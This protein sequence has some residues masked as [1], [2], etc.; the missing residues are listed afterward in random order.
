MYEEIVFWRWHLHVF[1]R[2]ERNLSPKLQ[3]GSSF[4]TKSP[5][6][7]KILLL[8]SSCNDCSTSPR[9]RQKNILSACLTQ[10]ELDKTDALLHEVSTI[11]DKQLTN[12][13]GLNE[14]WIVNLNLKERVNAAMKPWINRVVQ[15]R[16]TPSSPNHI[17]VRWPEMETSTDKWSRS[18]TVNRWPTTICQTCY[19][20]KYNRNHHGKCSLIDKGTLWAVWLRCGWV[21]ENLGVKEFG[22]AGHNLRGALTTFA[23]KISTIETDVLVENGRIYTKL[24]VYVQLSGW[25]L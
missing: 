3:S 10:G 17:H 21:E 20:L 23:R 22:A 12:H 19:V 15:Q 14:K 11:Q 5:S 2:R 16:R 6:V 8:K 7:F 4:G 13:K 9:H 25:F 24:E 1:K 18:I